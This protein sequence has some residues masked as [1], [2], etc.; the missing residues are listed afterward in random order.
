MS[1]DTLSDRIAAA[2]MR[3]DQ[4]F[5]DRIA[6]S[7]LSRQQWSLVMTAV[8][9]RVEDGDDPEAAR[10]VADTSKLP[11]VM[12]QV[13]NAGERGPMGG[14][15]PGDGGGGGSGG[16]IF[17]TVADA[18]GFGGD[19]D[20]ADSALE[21]EAEQLAQEYADQL[22]AHLQKRGRWDAIRSG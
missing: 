21:G 17:S 7:S 4:E 5:E 22:Q 19:S 16:G 14:P 2:R 8:E 6:A 10:L 12:E 18:L 11:S 20:G 13:E 9:F 15:A 1:D 3:V